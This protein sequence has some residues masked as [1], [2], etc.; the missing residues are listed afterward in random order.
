MSDN[1]RIIDSMPWKYMIYNSSPFSSLIHIQ[2][3]QRISSSCS[4]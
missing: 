1:E 4:N 2:N 3:E